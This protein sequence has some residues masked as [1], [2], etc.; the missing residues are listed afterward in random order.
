[1]RVEIQAQETFNESQAEP[2]VKP[3]FPIWWIELLRPPGELS[4]Y[5]E[6]GPEEPYLLK[7]SPMISTFRRV[8][9]L[10]SSS[11]SGSASRRKAFQ[12]RISTAVFA[13]V[14]DGDI[15]DRGGW[16]IAIE[17]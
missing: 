14:F 11:G 7:L 2:F 4:D 8:E 16:E 13:S 5:A 17:W 12:S 15:W 9:V 6:Q 3:E 10:L 1:M